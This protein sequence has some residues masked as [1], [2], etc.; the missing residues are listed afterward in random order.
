MTFKGHSLRYT[1][2][3]LFAVLLIIG[4]CRVHAQAGPE[5]TYRILLLEK[6]SPADLATAKK[7][8]DSIKLSG[9]IQVD[10]AAGRI[11][12]GDYATQAEADAAKK[13]LYEKESLIAK[14][15]IAVPKTSATPTPATT[16]TNEVLTIHVRDFKDRDKAEEL[17]RKLQPAYGSVM[18]RQVGSFFEVL[19]GQYSDKEAPIAL[20]QLKGDGFVN[21]VVETLPAAGAPVPSGIMIA[22]VVPEGSAAEERMLPITQS[23]IWKKLS[24]EEKN[25][26]KSN[27]EIQ[28]EIRKGD[29]LAGQLFD[30][31]KR[32]DNLDDR[33]KKIVDN[34]DTEKKALDARR[35]TINGDLE[36]AE[37]DIKEEK[38]ADAL[39]K[40]NEIKEQD[41]EGIFGVRE[42]VARRIEVVQSMQKGEHYPGQ[43]TDN[44]TKVKALQQQAAQL[45]NSM[46]T[47]ELLVSKQLWS[48]IKGLAP[49]LAQEADKHIGKI[50]NKINQVRDEEK[51]ARAEDDKKTKMIINGLIGAVSVL[52]V[53][54][55]FLG[56]RTRKRHQELMRKVQEI[57]SIRPMRELEGSGPQ[58]LGG[59][60]DVFSPMNASGDGSVDPLGGVLTPPP[61]PD[62]KGKGKKGKGAPA[63]APAPANDALDDI[64]GSG[65]SAPAAGGSDMGLDDIFGAPTQAPAA[66]PKATVAAATPAAQ[67]AAQP[68]ASPNAGSNAAASD[69]DDIFGGLFAEETK[70]PVAQPARPQD[71]TDSPA[72][73]TGPISFSDVISGAPG[74]PGDTSSQINANDLLSVMDEPVPTATSKVPGKGVDPLQDSPFASMFSDQPSREAVAS[75]A[76]SKDD[77]TEI[78]SIKLDS[79]VAEATTATP[80]FG[81]FELHDISQAGGTMPA[82]ETR[83]L[84]AFSFDDFMGGAALSGNGHPGVDQ[85]FERDTAG[86]LPSGWEGQYPFASLTVEADTPPKGSQQYLHFEKKDGTGKAHYSCHFGDVSGVIGIEF[87]LRCNDKNKFLLGFYVEKDGDFQHSIHTKILRSE[88]QTSP[89]IHMQGQPAPYLLGSWAH[90]KYVVDL[91]E[92]RINGYIDSTHVVR[93]LPLSPNP[94][95]LNT[96]SIRDNINTTGVLLLANIK[97]Y[98][99]H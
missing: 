20:G 92:G 23:E 7:L 16:P 66:A 46:D 86:Q 37:K 14:G 60:E 74:N 85:D 76:N 33:V 1:R 32:I 51:T 2:L 96:L 77:E 89:T 67:P 87:D 83:D 63:P 71:A 81:G 48:E 52:L 98:E 95:T 93:D 40:L 80:S 3:G 91:T 49:A 79:T 36:K 59:G 5:Q 50:A 47:G 17:K 21:A 38:Y 22:A 25:R 18:I 69:I 11:T 72:H 26:V 61:P 90:I 31:K 12:Y 62:K 99:I 53:M 45:E 65:P 4:I 44:Q 42:L 13:A 68:A 64:F 55:L 78:P 34:Y 54:I 70:P 27:V 8:L 43:E 41:K 6:K 75:N 39:L 88:A 56:L 73:D 24:E 10:E 35:L 28:Q 15:V 94:G 29:P 57:T 97:I 30:L 82:G 19:V 58:L 9:P 84:P